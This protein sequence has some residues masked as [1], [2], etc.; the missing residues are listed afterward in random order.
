[1]VSL[2]LFFFSRKVAKSQSLKAANCLSIIL[3][4]LAALREIKYSLREKAQKINFY[5]FFFF[6]FAFKAPRLRGSVFLGIRLPGPPKLTF[7][8]LSFFS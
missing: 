2:R 6:A 7:L 5:F 1:M 4:D 8:F 3:C